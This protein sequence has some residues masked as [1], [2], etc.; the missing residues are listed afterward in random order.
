MG[1]DKQLFEDEQSGNYWQEENF[2]DFGEGTDITEEKAN[3]RTGQNDNINDN[4]YSYTNDLWFNDGIWLNEKAEDIPDDTGKEGAEQGTIDLE[5]DRENVPEEQEL[6]GSCKQDVDWSSEDYTY[7]QEPTKGNYEGLEPECT[8]PQD[9]EATCGEDFDSD[10][11]EDFNGGCR[12]ES[13]RELAADYG[14]ADMPQ[15]EETSY[16]YDDE[17]AACRDCEDRAPDCSPPINQ[18][19]NFCEYAQNKNGYYFGGQGKILKFSFN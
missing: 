6:C 1:F 9:T 14:G 13:D 12:E 3:E 16:N 5:E 10:G 4:S 2:G 17:E 7:P 19:E 11:I 8:S 15:W 18:G